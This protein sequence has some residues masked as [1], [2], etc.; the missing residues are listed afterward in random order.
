MLGTYYMHATQRLIVL[1]ICAML[2]VKPFIDVEDMLRTKIDAT[3]TSRP[4]WAIPYTFSFVLKPANEK[5][6]MQVIES[7]HF[8]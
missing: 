4:T 2:Y 1:H 6:H 5:V 3:W 7:E 8:I